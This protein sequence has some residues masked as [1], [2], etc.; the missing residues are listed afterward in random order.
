MKCYLLL[1]YSTWK[2]YCYSMW[3]SCQYWELEWDQTQCSYLSLLVCCFIVQKKKY[4]KV[5][6]KDKFKNALGLSLKKKPMRVNGIWHVCFSFKAFFPPSCEFDLKCNLYI[7]KEAWDYDY[8]FCLGWT[9]HCTIFRGWCNK[10][11]HFYLKMYNCL[12]TVFQKYVA[13]RAIL[14]VTN[15]GPLI[16]SRLFTVN[17]V[18]YCKS[19]ICCLSAVLSSSHVFF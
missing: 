5:R 8:F 16:F 6:K 10:M 12:I 17:K 1:L 15:V 14:A 11:K 18:V 4:L 3:R 19:D 9:Y 2:P 7:K 13:L